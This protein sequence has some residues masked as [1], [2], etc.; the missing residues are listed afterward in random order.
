MQARYYDPLIGRFYSNDPVEAVSHLFRTQGI[1]GFNRYSYVNSNPYKYIDP[2]GRE[3]LYVG[4]TGGANAG[5]SGAVAS[6]VF[7]DISAEGITVGTYESAEIGS[8]T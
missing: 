8:S 2:D 4:I 5:K 1:Q 3:V 7:L 6:G